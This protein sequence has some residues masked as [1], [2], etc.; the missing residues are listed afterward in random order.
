[1]FNSVIPS[2]NPA[3]THSKAGQ[4]EFLFDKLLSRIEKI[5]PAQIVSYDRKNNRAVV[6]IL[7]QSITSEGG[8]VTKKVISDIPALNLCGGGFVFSFPIKP[9]DI[10]WIC[11]ADRNISIFKQTLKIFAPA[12]YE[13]HRY[14]DGFFIPN[15]INGFEYSADDENAVILTSLDGNT[16]ISIKNNQVDIVANSVNLGGYSGAFVLTENSV[17]TDG[18]GRT[19]T[20]VSNTTKTKAV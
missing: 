16:K 20:I 11:A 8:K 6:Q 18:E 9:G 12:T 10:G 2:N 19:C 3:D 4:T 7:N 14:K 15:H 1:M 13:K 17:I 5:A